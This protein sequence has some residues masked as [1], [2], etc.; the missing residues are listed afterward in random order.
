MYRYFFF[1]NP[2]KTYAPSTSSVDPV[3]KYT[4]RIPTSELTKPPTS[5]PTIEPS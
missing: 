4:G 1:N 3:K 5:G 2:Q